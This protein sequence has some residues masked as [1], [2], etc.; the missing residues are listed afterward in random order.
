[1]INRRL[2]RVLLAV[3]FA[4]ATVAVLTVGLTV[5]LTRVFDPHNYCDTGF[6]MLINCNL[7]QSSTSIFQGTPDPA[8]AAAS[9]STS[10]A[11]SSSP[12]TFKPGYSEVTS[13]AVADCP[14]N[15]IA[16]RLLCAVSV[17]APA[18]AASDDLATGL[19]R[20]KPWLITAAKKTPFTDSVHIETPL[21]LAV[22][23]GF[24]RLELSK[25]GWTENDG[26]VVAPD[27]AVIA[28]TTT[29]GP[30]LLRIIRQ[31]DRTIADLLLHK[32]AAGD[33]GI[34]PK[35]GQVRL[36]LG[37]ATD[38]EAVITINEQTINLAARAGRN[39]TDDLDDE[40][41]SPEIDLPPGKFK[42]N[43]KVASKAAQNREFEVAADETWGLLVGPAGVPLPLRLY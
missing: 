7:Q 20:P 17:A 36:M 15:S 22:V 42:V 14:E 26:A 19:P 12:R 29:D 38:E 32:P 25:R 35:P 13:W 33:A 9:R 28:F 18:K 11:P 3:S 21:D 8:F 24:Y 40:R 43:L 4:V 10:T 34:Q 5:A 41:K 23:L 27:R 1:M 6:S 16:K 31:N 37:N 2:K 39:L 30:A